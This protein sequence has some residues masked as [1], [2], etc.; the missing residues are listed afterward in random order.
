MSEEHACI[1]CHNQRLNARSI[2]ADLRL[3]VRKLGRSNTTRQAAADAKAK[4]VELKGR[5]TSNREWL[6]QHIL[7]AA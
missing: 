2:E 7:E 1:K 5:L 4:I 3:Q 6:K